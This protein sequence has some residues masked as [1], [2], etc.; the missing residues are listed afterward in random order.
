MRKKTKILSIVLGAVLTVVTGLFLASPVSFASVPPPTNPNSGGVGL[1][2]KNVQ[3]PPTTGA[4]ISLPNSG[5]TFGSLPVTVSGICPNDLLVKLYDNGVFVGSQQCTS[6]SFSIQIDLFAGSNQLVAKVFDDLDQPGPDSNTVT[7]TFNDPVAS[8][9]DRV[10]LTSSFAKRG[11]DPGTE[12]QWPIS[13]SGGTA[14]YALSV[15]WGDGTTPDLISQ[16]SAGEMTLKH[17]YAKA[18]VYKVIIKATDKNGVV[19]FLQLIGVG[20]GPVST[21]NGKSASGTTLIK[22]RVIWEPALILL[23]LIITSFYFG[24]RYKLKK[25]RGRVERGLPPI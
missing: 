10:T 3:P 5:A 7:V 17:K 21:N 11:A 24:Q 25:I 4:T 2:G 23:P 15:D 14:P 16:A 20:N 13:I 22:T 6:G 9:G 1:Q 12:L 18:G 19:A 8:V